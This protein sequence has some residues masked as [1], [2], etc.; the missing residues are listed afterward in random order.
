MDAKMQPFLFE[1]EALV[2][3]VDKGD[4]PWFVLADTCRVLNIDNSSRAAARLDEDE[5]GVHTMNTPGGVQDMT[6]ISESGL[7]SLILTSRKPAARRF[8]KWITS[9][10]LPSIRRTGGYQ[11]MPVERIVP[12]DADV[13]PKPFEEWTLEEIRTHLAVANSYR[14]T[15]NNGS[16]AWYLM[17]TGFPRPPERLMPAWWQAD[18]NLNRG[19]DGRAVVV[20][21]VPT[22]GNSH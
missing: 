8:K 1:G 2:R 16:A 18:M 20:V 11:S 17:R 12:T 15:L 10:V 6:I 7:Y 3:V 19:G 9:E 4:A 22:G 14:H 21:T 5:K 13:R